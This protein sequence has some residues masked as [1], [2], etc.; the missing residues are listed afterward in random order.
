MKV[1]IFISLSHSFRVAFYFVEV[2]MLKHK[3]IIKNGANINESSTL[4]TVVRGKY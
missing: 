3:I 2:N 4:R 1:N